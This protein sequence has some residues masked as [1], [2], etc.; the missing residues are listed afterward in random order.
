MTA[1]PSTWAAR[2][3]ARQSAFAAFA[4]VLFAYPILADLPTFDPESWIN[5]SDVILVGTLVDVRTWSE[6]NFDHGRGILQITD[7]LASDPRVGSELILEW[8]DQK[9]LVCPRIENEQ[10][11]GR[12]GLWF[13]RR[14]A[15]GRLGSAPTFRD[16]TREAS[17][18]YFAAAIDRLV[19][20][21]A[22]VD[23]VRRL[24]KERLRK[25]PPTPFGSAERVVFSN[26]ASIDFFERRGVYC[27]DD[28]LLVLRA[29]D[30]YT[31]GAYSRG[32]ANSWRA[33]GIVTARPY[34]SYAVL[35][36]K[37]YA[38]VLALEVDRTSPEWD[39]VAAGIRSKGGGMTAKVLVQRGISSPAQA[40]SADRVIA[41]AAALPPRFRTT[42]G[43]LAVVF[44]T[45][46]KSGLPTIIEF[47]TEFQALPE[48]PTIVSR[49]KLDDEKASEAH[50]F[51]GAA[52]VPTRD[53]TGFVK[54]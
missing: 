25:L 9:N 22:R 24:L 26:G 4:M 7:V 40:Q 43:A 23:R 5:R 54:Y 12:E 48:V 47:L 35:W 44:R 41:A 8:S 34:L 11:A 32:E 18:L 36:E 6:G 53:Q 50:A 19:L 15:D 27:P 2:R 45:D 37:G 3:P 51:L 28:A 17:I 30:G 31:V 14:S 52:P 16:L 29:S 33:P 13:F 39:N 21:G 38:S 1:N 46:E 20:D 10:Y 42:L 49:E